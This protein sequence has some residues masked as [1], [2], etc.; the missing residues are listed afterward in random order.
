MMQ[1]FLMISFLFSINSYCATIGSLTLRGVV[2]QLV[3][4]S[5]SSETIATS[6]PLDIT[7]NDTKVAT[8]N[9]RSNSHTGYSIVISSANSG[10]LKR[11]SGT[12]TLS[13]VLKYNGSTVNLAS[14]QTFNYASAGVTNIDRDI[15]ISYTGS[16]LS[17]VK[18][19]TYE[20]T[21]TFSISSI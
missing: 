18:S 12:E 1:K 6:L 21:V 11:V 7:Q 17:T 4:V 2:P 14:G 8:I 16:D 13:Y 10:N 9:E 15:N 3:S 19:G 20:D 5:V